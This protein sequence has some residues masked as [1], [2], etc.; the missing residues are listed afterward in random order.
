MATYAEGEQAL[1][2]L[3]RVGRWPRGRPEE[4]WGHVLY[5]TFF[6]MNT[7]LDRIIDIWVSMGVQ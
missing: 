1:S 5:L 6:K 7:V 4:R 3:V 2:T